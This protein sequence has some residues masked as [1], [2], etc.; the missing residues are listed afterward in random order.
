[1]VPAQIKSDDYF[2]DTN[3]GTTALEYLPSIERLTT[4]KYAKI[5]K[6]ARVHLKKAKKAAV[7]RVAVKNVTANM[8]GLIPISSDVEMS[9]D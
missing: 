2:S 8:R 3:W 6:Q 5:I 4:Q 9:S 7:A 1:L